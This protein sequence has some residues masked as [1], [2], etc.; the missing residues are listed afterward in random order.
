[1]S[2]FF[3]PAI[4]EN[5]DE[6]IMDH[7]RVHVE[8]NGGKSKI[9]SKEKRQVDPYYQSQMPI[10]S[11]ASHVAPAA[12]DREYKPQI[13]VNIE[14]EKKRDEIQHKRRRRSLGEEYT[15]DIRIPE[16]VENNLGVIHQKRVEEEVEDFSGKRNKILKLVKRQMYE[17]PYWEPR[18]TIHGVK[19]MKNPILQLLRAAAGQKT[20]RILGLNSKSF[21]IFPGPLPDERNIALNNNY[22]KVTTEAPTGRYPQVDQQILKTF[23][24]PYVERAQQPQYFQQQEIQPM[25]MYPQQQ[26]GYSR[27]VLQHPMEVAQ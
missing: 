27:H 9:P 2:Q 3:K 22:G 21:D 6:Q 23:R 16:G 5:N 11:Y 17:P 14:T 26:A 19:A 1:M 20:Q 7:V 25:T 8:S 24:Q 18:A 10:P 13:H 15:K 4:D 12:V